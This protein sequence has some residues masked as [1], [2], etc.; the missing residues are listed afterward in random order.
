MP[1]DALPLMCLVPLIARRPVRSHVN[2]MSRDLTPQKALIFRVTHAR[3]FRWILGHGLFSAGSGHADPNFV[4]IGNSDLIDRRRR[5]ALPAP[6]RG[7]LSDYVPFYFTPF[8]P[9]MLNIK[10][11]W[12]G[13]TKR[14][15]EDLVILVSSIWKLREEGVPVVF[16][17]RHAYLRAARFFD[18]PAHLDQIDWDILQRRDFRRDPND[19]EKFE[20]YE[21]E[22][23]ALSHVPVGALLG[24]A[25]YNT[26]ANGR[27]VEDMKAAGMTMKTVVQPGWYFQ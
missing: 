10:T 4:A 19:L 11:G 7:V 9:M 27:L 5:R 22:A 17:D 6:H 3:N 20:R 18:D 21:A 25:C 8:S 13:I 16:S 24:V 14:A 23:L 26:A 1:P 15:N 2:A 12:G